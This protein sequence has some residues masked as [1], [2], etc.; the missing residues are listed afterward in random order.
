M[1]YTTLVLPFLLPVPHAQLNTLAKAGG[2]KYFGTA[3]DNPELTD[4]AYVAALSNTSDFGQITPGNSQKWDT[5]EPSN[6]TSSFTNGDAITALAQKN[7]QLV[8][9]H[10]LV[11]YSQLPSWVSDGTWTNAT[12]TA[13]LKTHI[14][15]EVTHYKGQCYAWDVVNEALNDDATFRADVFY[16][17]LG[18][19]FIRIAFE[20]AATADPVVKLYY[21]DY[22]I[23]TA[24]A[25][26]SAALNI[27]KK[28][29]AA[30]T[31]INGSFESFAGVEVALTE[32]DIRMTLPSTT[33]LLTQQSTD[34]ENA[35]GACV[36]VANC[37]GVTYSWVPSTFSG[38]GAACLFDEDLERKPAYYGVMSALSGAKQPTV[39]G[40]V[41]TATSSSS[42][43]AKSA[44]TVVL[45]PSGI[46]TSYIALSTSAI[47]SSTTFSTI[48]PSASAV[49]VKTEDDDACEV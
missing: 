40:L 26:A 7:D 49:A 37:V 9:C 31:K 38:Q 33:A 3:T 27:V 21:H 24:G 30:G 46:T 44:T 1:L 5:I 8:R 34:Y 45:S 41:A 13:V 42:S 43:A 11:W 48:S 22:D 17:A 18:E 47:T 28:L 12:L 32:L 15:T 20:T 16:N 6:G 36:A 29:Q 4:T 25:K 2:L 14:T 19:D 39:T 35:V 23:E 10:N